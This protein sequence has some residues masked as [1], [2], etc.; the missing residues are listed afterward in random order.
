MSRLDELIKEKCPDGV[1]YRTLENLEDSGIITLGRGKVIS[2]KDIQNNPGDYPIYSSSAVGSG[3][4]GTYGDY[5]FDDIRISWSIDGGG[6]FFYRNAPRYSVTNV[7]GW[8]TVDNTGILDIRYL[9]F[10][11]TNEWS[12]KVFDYVH[13]AHPSV[14]RK[15][16][17][18]PVP[19]IEVQREI[20]RMLDSFTELEAELEAELTKRKLQYRF[21]NELL[22]ENQSC[23][24]KKLREVADI[25]DSLHSTPKYEK[26]GYPMVRVADVKFGVINIADTLRVSEDVFKKFTAK[27]KPVKNDIVISRVGTYGNVC[28]VGDDEVC[29]GQNT[30]VIHPTKVNA[31]YLY[32]YLASPIAQNW[33]KVNVNGAGYKS[34]SLASINEI[35]VAVPDKE[36]QEEVVSIL[37]SFE[38][39]N[40][41]LINGIPAEIDARHKQYEYYR[42][43]LL[44]FKEKVVR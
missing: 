8:L 15:E 3:I 7:C 10:V 28:I 31:R 30:S 25:I 41:D 40:N 19:P 33:I 22:F 6:K 21:Y 27:Y 17:N 18:I 29:L 5:M 35:P 44:T 12:K 43:K 16:Y 26:E 23:G 14:I 34:L 1:E 38:S 37:D 36:T 11:L 13:K 42:D 2:K 24:M 32:Y 20:V 4:F 39:L 9:F